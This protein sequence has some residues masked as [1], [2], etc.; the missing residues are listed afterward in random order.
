MHDN[1]PAGGLF[2]GLMSGTSAD[3]IDAALVDI[4]PQGRCH[5]V[6]GLT[7]PWE[8]RLRERLL[9]LGQGC[10]PDGLDDLGD[11]DARIG[12][13]F[14]DAANALLSAAGVPPGQ[15]RAIGSHGQT[16][17]HRPAAALPFTL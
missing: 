10:E 8:P 6:Q 9:A 2:I 12:L 4:T 3:G 5:F 1:Q 11:L 14:A 16:V 17:R 13:A 15:V 7:A